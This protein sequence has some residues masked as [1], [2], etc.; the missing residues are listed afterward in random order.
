MPDQP[1]TAYCPR[2]NQE[3]RTYREAGLLKYRT[4]DHVPGGDATC[5]NSRKP[6]QR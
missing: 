5:K 1:S 2:C 6:V 4:H 3:V